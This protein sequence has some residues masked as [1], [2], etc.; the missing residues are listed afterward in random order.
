M[1]DVGRVAQSNIEVLMLVNQTCPSCYGTEI[2][3]FYEVANVPVNSV[4][5]LTTQ[6]QALNF[7]TGHISLGFC[8]TCGFIFNQK[9]RPE[10]TE[11]SSRYESTQAYSPTFS[12]FAHKLAMGLIE[13]YDLRQKNIIEI[14]CGQGEFLTHLCELGDNRG[15]GF[16]PAFIDERIDSATKQNIAFI[17]DFYSEK[18]AQYQ[19]DFLCCKMTL[20]HIG[21]TDEFLGMVR[22]SIGDRSNTIVYFQVP[23]AH[24][25]LNEVAFWD[26]YYEHCSYFSKGSL[27][28]L[29]RRNGFD[30]LHLDTT[31]GNQYLIIEAQPIDGILCGTDQ[32]DRT[33]NELLEEDDLAILEQAVQDYGTTVHRR[34]NHWRNLIQSVVDAGQQVVLWGGGSKAVAFLTTLKITEEIEYAVDINPLKHGTFLPATGQQVIAP[35]TLRQLSPKLVIAMNPI[36]LEEIRSDLQRLD[37]DAQLMGLE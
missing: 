5:L 31:Y 27:A 36:Y 30:V 7:P 14:G 6:E 17:K 34:H 25:V 37:V 18:Y 9:F 23:N 35:D 22:R 19:G 1:E 26:V 4:L 15:V 33:R 13:K 21:K 3:T 20:E 29:F 32:E 2:C 16:D 24:Y 28:R 12:S 10:L 8:H 11:Y